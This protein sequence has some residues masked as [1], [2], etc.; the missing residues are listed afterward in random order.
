MGSTTLTDQG[1]VGGEDIASGTVTFFPAIAVNINE[2]VIIGFSASAPT[3]F[4]GAYY[5]GRFVGDPA[6]FVNPSVVVRAGLDS[7]VRTFGAGRNRWGD[8]TGASVDP[9][10]DK[11]FWI[12]NEYA[13][14]RGTPTP[15][16]DGRWGTVYAHVPL[17]DL[18]V[19]LTS[20]AATVD[21]ADVTLS[22]S[23]A[24]ETNNQGF[25]IQRSKAENEY[26]KIGYVPG[27]GTTTEIQTYSYTDSKVASGNYTYR[28]KQIDYDGTIDYSNEVAVEVTAPLEFVLEQNY[29]NPFNP[30]TLIKY[31]IPENGFVNLD[32]YNL[33]GEKVASLVNSVQEAGRYEVNFDASELAS[34]IYVY[35]L[36]SGS[37]NS[38]KKM[39]LMK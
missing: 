25:E 39:L 37:F 36:K 12:F 10:D 26:E 8:Y 21:E 1:D 5:A 34:S 22:W 23:T 20:F 2:D 30:S 19:E 13:I 33:L 18:P 7:Y 4:P 29:P 27:H 6:G 32:V 24:T 16:E 31:S 17:S 9:T 11:S 28:L 14:A 3:I 38:V 15:P 35:S